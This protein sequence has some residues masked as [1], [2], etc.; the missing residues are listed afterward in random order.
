MDNIEEKIIID[1]QAIANRAPKQDS[2][3]L[4]DVMKRFLLYL[5]G[6]LQQGPI[7]RTGGVPI[8]PIDFAFMITKASYG[9]PQK[10]GKYT[11]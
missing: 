1:L 4:Y 9:L 3:L 6:A 7:E 8:T 5:N 10:D 11:L 2:I